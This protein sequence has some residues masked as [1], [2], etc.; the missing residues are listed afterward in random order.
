ML[1]LLR[2][3]LH[4][5][6]RATP[7]LEPGVILRSSCGPPHYLPAGWQRDRRAR[8]LFGPHAAFE[9]IRSTAA[10]SQHGREQA[11]A[12]H[13]SYATSIVFLGNIECAP[14]SVCC[15]ISSVPIL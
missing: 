3:A 10:S 9:P 13:A 14:D 6:A 2:I 4:P 11:S 1:L 15:E 5:E 8:S 12:E 7:T